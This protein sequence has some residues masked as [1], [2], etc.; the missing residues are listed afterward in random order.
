LPHGPLYSSEGTGERR[1]KEGSLMLHHH[2]RMAAQDHLDAAQ[3]VDAAA[4]TVHVAH[5]N[6]DALDGARI[7]PELVAESSPKVCPV[8]LVEPDAVDSDVRGCQRCRR[9]TG[10]PFD[11]P[12]HLIRERF[13]LSSSH[14]DAFA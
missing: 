7:L 11:G 3:K 2:A 9:P 5:P 14:A 1:S 6:G 13:S 12:G 4:R 10:S 8:I